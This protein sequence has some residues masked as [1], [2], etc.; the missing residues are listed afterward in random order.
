[1]NLVIVG[2]NTKVCEDKQVG[3]IAVNLNLNF[4]KN[5]LVDENVVPHTA[6]RVVKSVAPEDGLE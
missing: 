1:L 3:D 4:S 6:R 5:M 2:W